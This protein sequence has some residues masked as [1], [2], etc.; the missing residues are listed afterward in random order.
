MAR[1]KKTATKN[2]TPVIVRNTDINSLEKRVFNM[3][4]AK[5]RNYDIFS[6]EKRIY[7]LEVNGGGGGSSLVFDLIQGT[8]T[9]TSD[10]NAGTPSAKDNYTGFPA[11]N[12]FLKTGAWIGY[13]SDTYW[14]F[15]FNDVTTPRVIIWDV[16]DAQRDQIPTKYEISE[17]GVEFT[18]VVPDYKSNGILID[19]KTKSKIKAFRLCFVGEYSTS[20][21]PLLA[22]VNI[23]GG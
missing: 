20:T 12:A 16:T 6:L 14:Q 18:E 7:D 13:S 11:E 19:T 10:I 9:S 3:D 1:T 23:I 22:N 5:I 17:D 21:Y 8:V 4:G 2:A 15:D